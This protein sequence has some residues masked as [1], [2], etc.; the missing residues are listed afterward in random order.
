[1]QCDDQ[2]DRGD[3]ERLLDA[4]ARYRFV[5]GSRSVSSPI[6]V[7]FSLLFALGFGGISG[8]FVYAV[9]SDI[10]V[11]LR[12]ERFPT[13]DG[14]VV[15][16]EI[17]VV[18]GDEGSHE[19]PVLE[20]RYRVGDRDYTTT[21]IRFSSMSSIFDEPAR[22][23]IEQNP[24]GSRV[25]V[26]YD[27]ARPS[28]ACLEPG[29][30]WA[31]IASLVFMLPFLLVAIVAA[32]IPFAYKGEP[33]PLVR[34]TDDGRLVRFHVERSHWAMSV[35]VGSLFGTFV[36]CGCGTCAAPVGSRGVGFATFVW[37]C[38]IGTILAFLGRFFRHRR[39]GRWDLEFDRHAKTLRLPPASVFGDP[40]IVDIREVASIDVEARKD[41]DSDTGY[42]TLVVALRGGKREEA[43]L[44]ILVDEGR[45]VAEAIRTRAGMPAGAP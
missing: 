31:D 22:T 41:P 30:A 18:E 5:S 16:S 26:F 43:Q 1:V 42:T 38:A 29:I 6:V 15:R 13:A 32:A 25:R 12:A 4:Q 17:E 27:P 2:G 33:E 3:E 7:L 9:L 37:L 24:I 36:A 21:T 34:E 10:P 23:R 8:G 39:E 40:R 45:L 44:A 28:R 14:E 19:E 35:L 20:V 11:S